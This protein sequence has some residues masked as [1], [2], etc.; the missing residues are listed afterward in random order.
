MTSVLLLTRLILLRN[1]W[2][3]LLLMVWPVLIA[4]VIH[5]LGAG[6][7]RE[8][9]AALLH[10]ESLYGIAMVAFAGSALLGAEERSGRIQIVLGRAVARGSYLAAL[11][12]AAWLPLLLYVAGFVAAGLLLR[13]DASGTHLH[14]WREI[15]L[16]AASQLYLG[17]VVAAASIFF[18]VVLPTAF[19][20]VS[21]IVAAASTEY[22]ANLF[23]IGTVLQLLCAVILAM[24]IFAA[25]VAAFNRR[26]LQLAKD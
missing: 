25:A 12:L 9:I 13:V 11:L 20:S 10:Q 18:S 23:R 6:M 22:L 7:N 16:L 26:D 15:A 2:L 5:F 1:K 3:I 24:V 17:I 19:A 21:T 14:L 4:L 8:D